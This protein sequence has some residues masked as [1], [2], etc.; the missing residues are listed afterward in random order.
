MPS[1][2]VYI[3]I[4]THTQT[5]RLFFFLRQR[6][7]M[8][9]KSFSHSLSNLGVGDKCKLSCVI[10]FYFFFLPD[11]QFLLLILCYKCTL[12]CYFQ[13]GSVSASYFLPALISRNFFFLNI[14]FKVTGVEQ[15]DSFSLKG[16]S[17]KY[18]LILQFFYDLTFDFLVALQFLTPLER[19]LCLN[20]KQY[21][22]FLIR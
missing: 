21:H 14:V 5:S 2:C 7:V 10:L 18:A 9:H 11:F 22:Y 4:Y 16:C 1:L 3:Y 6:I 8:L 19:I 17:T 12:F 15:F 20:E 13:V